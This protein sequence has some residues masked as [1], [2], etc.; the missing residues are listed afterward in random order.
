MLQIMLPNIS[1]EWNIIMNTKYC[2]ESGTWSVKLPHKSQKTRMTWETGAW[3]IYPSADMSTEELPWF[4]LGF[5][6][7]E[8]A[9]WE[10]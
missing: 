1:T 10:K 6:L 3:Y 7:K 4:V 8:E 5:I 2:Y 9:G